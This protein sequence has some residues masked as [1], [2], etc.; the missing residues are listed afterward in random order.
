MRPLFPEYPPP[1]LPKLEG[2][3]RGE[4]FQAGPRGLD[5]RAQIRC[6]YSIRFPH[7]ALG[8][9]IKTDE[10]GH[11]VQSPRAVAV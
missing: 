2:R 7:D 5:R 11:S 6:F 3:Q 4:R 1:V 8:I 9:D 10:A